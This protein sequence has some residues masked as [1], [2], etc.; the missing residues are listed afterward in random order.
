MDVMGRDVLCGETED[1]QPNKPPYCHKTNCFT[2]FPGS[3]IQDNSFAREF[4]LSSTYQVRIL[5]TTKSDSAY[6]EA[7]HGLSDIN[8]HTTGSYS[9]KLH[10]KAIS[11]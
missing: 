3:F 6:P 5:G 4:T 2:Q 11:S 1:R 10:Q 7:K 9:L 8:E